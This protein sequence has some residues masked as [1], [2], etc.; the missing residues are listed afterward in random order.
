MTTVSY[1]D[2]TTA[3]YGYDALSRLTSAANTNGTVTFGY[4]NR[5]RVASTTTEHL[6][7]KRINNVR[8]YISGLT[9]SG[10]T[11]GGPNGTMRLT[12]AQPVH[13]L[14]TVSREENSILTRA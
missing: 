6:W 14:D 9:G 1:P 4:D 8:N 3:S 10:T 7:V 5:A 13:S 12:I 2:T 11:F